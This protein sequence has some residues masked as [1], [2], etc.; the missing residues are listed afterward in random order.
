MKP[1]S[2]IVTIDGPAGA[3][4]TTLG[5]ALADHLGFE[6]LSSGILYRAI[7]FWIVAHGLDVDDALRNLS[8]LRAREIDAGALARSDVVAAAVEAAAAPGVRGPV[9]RILRAYADLRQGVVV[10]GRDIGTTVFPDAGRKLYLTATPEA[11]RLRAEVREGRHSARQGSVSPLVRD[12]R[13]RERLASPLQPADGALV[14]DTTHLSAAET[15][16]FALAYVQAE[17]RTDG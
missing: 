3:G 5:I 10:D 13:D 14:L 2:R 7:G 1:G 8:V 11:R 15:L 4:K 16:E 12:A 9:T 17:D 6:H